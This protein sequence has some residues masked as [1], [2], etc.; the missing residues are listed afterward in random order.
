MFQET[1]KVVDELNQISPLE[2]RELPVIFIKEMKFESKNPRL[3]YYPPREIPSLIP[4][5]TLMWWSIDDVFERV[6]NPGY[7]LFA[8]T[9]NVSAYSEIDAG[10]G[11]VVTDGEVED[12]DF[13]NDPELRELLQ[14]SKFEAEGP[15]TKQDILEY[16]RSELNLFVPSEKHVLLSET[17]S[18]S[19]E[20]EVSLKVNSRHRENVRVVIP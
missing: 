11:G 7:A 13:Y 4:P 1:C 15:V 20:H 17:L 18:K 14:R 2:K 12:E 6:I 19:G 8:T 9:E 16:L 5:G 10:S 3:E